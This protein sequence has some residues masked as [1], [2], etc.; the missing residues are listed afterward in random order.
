MNP[1]SVLALSMLVLAVLGT[2]ACE[3]PLAGPSADQQT[4]SDVDVAA[5]SQGQTSG[6]LVNERFTT[7][8][9]SVIPRLPRR[10]PA[11]GR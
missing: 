9:S 7:R 1:T 10:I 2:T 6:V 4:V 8:S 5:S 11:P 3:R